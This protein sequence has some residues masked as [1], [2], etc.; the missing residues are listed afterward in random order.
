M[1]K[2]LKIIEDYSGGTCYQ[3]DRFTLDHFVPPE[4]QDKDEVFANDR[5]FE[6]D[7]KKRQNIVLNMNGSVVSLFDYFLDGS[8]RVYKIVD[9]GTTDG[10][11]LP[12]VAG[13]IGAAICYRQ[14]KKLKKYKLVREN[15]IAVP[16]RL[17]D[18][19]DNMVQ[20][21]S[22][23][24]L[25]KNQSNSLSID[26]ILKYTVKTKP[27]RPFENLAV[28]KI[29][30]Q[31]YQLEVELIRD[32]VHSHQLKTHQMLIIDGSLQFGSV[33]D[34]DHIF[35]NVIGI[36][37]SFN[38]NLQGILKTKNTQIGSY[39]ANLEFKQRTPVFVYEAESKRKRKTKIGAWYL[40]IHPLRFMN[41]PLD[42]V[43][44]IEK[45]AITRGEKNDGFD[46]DMINEIS[47]SIL[48]E[49]NVTCYGNDERWANH[50]YPIYLTELLLKNS[51]A[52]DT[53]FLNI[54]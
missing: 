25:P 53:F 22:K 29:Q 23:L 1:G 11:F 14:H 36:S 16:D 6:T 10:K 31:M 50:I 2:I 44:K 54:F 39:L 41:K 35:Q 19:F 42:G 38:P 20:D 17:G 12:I 30:N 34:E 13:Q 40:R 7:H 24:K 33:E 18:D 5:I 9:F 27:E 21:I 28:A 37:K 47:R 48:L 52:S 32:M 4:Y 43:I 8:R 45:M 3:T 51:F 26:Q 15:V 46:T 49:R